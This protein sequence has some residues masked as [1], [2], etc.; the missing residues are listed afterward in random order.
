M[1]RLLKRYRELLVVAVLLLWPLASFLASG[2]K[3]ARAPNFLDRA[4]L[5]VTGPAQRGLHYLLDG[6]LAG[7]KGYLALTGVKRDNDA[8]RVENARLR[9]AVQALGESKLENERLRKLLQYTEQQAGPEIPARVVGVNPVSGLLSVRIDKGEN[10]GVFRGMAVVTPDG[11]V[12]QVVRATGGWADVALIRDRQSK[13]A[14]RVQRSR[15][16]ATAIGDEDNPLKLANALRTEDIVEGDVL[17]TAG[18]DGVYP[19]GL[20][21]GTVRSLEKKEHGMFQA[22]EIV[23]SVD[24]VKLEEVLVVPANPA[25]L[26]APFTEAAGGAAGEGTR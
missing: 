3:R 23:P 14:V 1:L 21:V 24:S 26:L 9:A 5:A 13:V 17:V 10:D 16:R 6:T 19:A 20:V 4:V 12:G 2:G 25:G 22:A 8:L 15:A 7:V 18:T 11:I